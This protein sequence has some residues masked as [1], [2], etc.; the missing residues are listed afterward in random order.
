MT[1]MHGMDVGNMQPASGLLPYHPLALFVEIDTHLTSVISLQQSSKRMEY[2]TCTG[3][4]NNDSGMSSTEKKIT[5]L[6]YNKQLM[7]A[8]LLAEHH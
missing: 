4:H 5:K 3:S 8:A 1:N 7:T 6:A 2:P